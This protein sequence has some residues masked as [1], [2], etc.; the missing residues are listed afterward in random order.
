[1]PSDPFSV[2]RKRRSKAQKKKN[3]Q[4]QKQQTKYQPPSKKSKIEQMMSQV[5]PSR[6]NSKYSSLCNDKHILHNPWV[7]YAHDKSDRDFSLKT[8]YK[9]VF[10]MTYIE[11]FWLFFNN[12]RDFS[13]HQF[14]IMRKD[15]PPIYECP[16]NRDGGAWSYIIRHER[17][18]D[19]HKVADTLIQTTIRMIGETL[20]ER[21]FHDQITGLYLNPKPNRSN[22]KIWMRDFRNPGDLNTDDIIG[23]TS[24]RF[25]P[26][27][28]GN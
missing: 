5:K 16:E 1:M 8:S 2:K 21:Q 27:N 11:D 9:K 14:Y 25:R 12:F 24:K 22:L 4:L 17:D 13:R 18:A 23:L 19:K 15:I 7:I 3:K 26:H 10:T 6:K 20:I 28:F